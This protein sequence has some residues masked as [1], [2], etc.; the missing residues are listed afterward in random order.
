MTRTYLL[1]SGSKFP[2]FDEEPPDLGLDVEALELIALGKKAPAPAHDTAEAKGVC[3]ADQT[4][5]VRAAASPPETALATRS[6]PGAPSR[7]R[8][9]AIRGGRRRK[10]ARG[11]YPRKCSKTAGQRAE[12]LARKRSTPDLDEDELLRKYSLQIK[13]RQQQAVNRAVEAEKQAREAKAESRELKKHL[14]E[15]TE[16]R[17]ALALAQ[18]A[19]TPQVA[20]ELQQQLSNKK[21]AAAANAKALVDAVTKAVS[22]VDD[23]LSD[24]RADLD[25]ISDE[26]QALIQSVQA[27]TA[28]FGPA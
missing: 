26:L 25:C 19:S 21:V 6:V 11:I 14:D 17:D 3:K 28:I 18:A 1:S 12:P 10:S 27:L 15:V 9:A 20:Q 16:E 24:A 22:K 5:L 8:P 13:R 23:S 4:A 2:I 7:A